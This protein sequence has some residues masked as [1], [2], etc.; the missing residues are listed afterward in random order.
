[1]RGTVVNVGL[2]ES[3]VQRQAM[4]LRFALVT[5]AAGFSSKLDCSSVA[6]SS[7]AQAPQNRPLSLRGYAPLGCSGLERP[8]DQCFRPSFLTSDF[9]QRLR[10]SAGFG[11]PGVILSPPGPLLGLLGV[12]LDP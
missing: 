10:R 9:E 8:F 4:T 7:W 11:D 12:F 3:E 1:V 5:S 6:G 2:R